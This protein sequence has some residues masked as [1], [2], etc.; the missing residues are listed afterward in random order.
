MGDFSKRSVFH[1]G[2]SRRATARVAPTDNAEQRAFV[3]RA[4]GD[5]I[6]PDLGIVVI[7]QADGFP[8]GERRGVHRRDLRTKIPKIRGKGRAAQV[9]RPYGVTAPVS[10]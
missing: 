3:R 10:P 8:A 5:E 2:R 4:D 9:C 6:D 7:L 1:I